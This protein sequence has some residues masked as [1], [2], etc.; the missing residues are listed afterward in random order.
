MVPTLPISGNFNIWELRPPSRYS[1]TLVS[2]C[3][4]VH[5]VK[6]AACRDPSSSTNRKLPTG[7]FALRM[8]ARL[9]PALFAHADAVGRTLHV[10][11]NEFGRCR[12]GD[13]HIGNDLA[14]VGCLGRI[15]LGVAFDEER[16]FAAGCRR[17][18]A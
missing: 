13:A 17:R 14:G 9:L 18:A 11:K 5:S 10:E 6:P 15:G 7:S 16:V 3:R 1:N 4:P 2:R 8:G 12:Q